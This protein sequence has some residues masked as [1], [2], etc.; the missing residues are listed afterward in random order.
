MRVSA[1]DVVRRFCEKNS[2]RYCIYENYSGRGM[3]GRSCLGI[4]IRDGSPYLP[5]MMEFT[6]FLDAYGFN[7]NEPEFADASFDSLGLSTIV[8]FPNIAE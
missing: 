1:A 4:V 7:G 2:D 6:G 3:F 5:V 8:Y